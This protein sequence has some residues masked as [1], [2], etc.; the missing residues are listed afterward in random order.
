MSRKLLVAP[1]D[2]R[3]KAE[4]ADLMWA[5]FRAEAQ[6]RETIRLVRLR[7]RKRNLDFKQYRSALNKDQQYPLF[8]DDPS[9]VVAEDLARKAAAADRM[10]AHF[11]DTE[12]DL[13]IARAIRVTMRKR[14]ADLMQILDQINKEEDYPLFAD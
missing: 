3:R 13:E 14:H 1:R 6:D 10:W 2:G 7:I 8:P 5:F 11:R 9:A 4:A 12:A